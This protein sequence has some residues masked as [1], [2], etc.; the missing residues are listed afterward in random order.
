MVDW[1]LEPRRCKSLGGVVAVRAGRLHT[2][3]HTMGLSDELRELVT[4]HEGGKLTDEEFVAAKQATIS[5]R[6]PSGVELEPEPEPAPEPGP[7]PSELL[8]LTEADLKVELGVRKL[9]HVMELRKALDTLRLSEQRA[10]LRDLHAATAEAAVRTSR[11]NY[12]K[13]QRQLG[14]AVEPQPPGRR[15]PAPP[16]VRGSAPEDHASADSP[17]GAGDDRRARARADGGTSSG[18]ADAQFREY[19]IKVFATPARPGRPRGSLTQCRASRKRC[20]RAGLSS[21]GQILGPP[22]AQ[23][24]I[25]RPCALSPPAVGS[26]LVPSK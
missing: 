23:V 2:G 17:R 5:A 15:Q 24:E 8:D 9:G 12:G 1:E 11:P 4:L 14:G 3:Q 13:D 18:R 7:E 21:S 10:A 20:S 16:A 19:I 26:A 25:P 6:T 22:W